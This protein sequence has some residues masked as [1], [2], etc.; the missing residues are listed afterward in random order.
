MTRGSG[1][2]Q[3][4]KRLD[5]R[6]DGRGVEVRLPLWA[7]DFSLLRNIQ[8][9]S[10]VRSASCKMGTGGRRRGIKLTTNVNLVPRLS[11]VEPCLHSIRLH[12]VVLN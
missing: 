12:G 10:E 1:I 11:I 6:L 7:R 3:S 4:V 8:T 5:Y 9:G 2:A